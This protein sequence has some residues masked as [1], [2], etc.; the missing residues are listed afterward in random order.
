MLA[1]QQVVVEQLDRWQ[2]LSA[3][4]A[5]GTGHE[6]LRSESKGWRHCTHLAVGQNMGTLVESLKNTIDTDYQEI[7]G[8]TTVITTK[9]RRHFL[10]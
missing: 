3:A 9:Y 6:G 2:C 10:F 7:H 8:N 1:D 4:D 5:G